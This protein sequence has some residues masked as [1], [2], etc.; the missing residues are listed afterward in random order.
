MRE[1]FNQLGLLAVI[2]VIVYGSLSSGTNVAAS[3]GGFPLHFVAYFVLAAAFLVN[4]HDTTRGHLEAIAASGFL[5]LGLELVQAFLPMRTFS[6]MDFGVS[7]VGATLI[8]L[9]HHL[10]AVT[11]FVSFEDRLIE[12]LFVE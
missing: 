3:G 2:A 1:R 5:A 11:W 12:R 9:D 6:L 4:F 8:T 10:D 7:F